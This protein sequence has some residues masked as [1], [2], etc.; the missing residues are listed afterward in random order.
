MLWITPLSWFKSYFD[1]KKIDSPFASY[2]KTMLPT[3]SQNINSKFK[4]SEAFLF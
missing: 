1:K 2:F 3:V 4:R